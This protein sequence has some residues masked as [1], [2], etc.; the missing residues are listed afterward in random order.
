MRFGRHDEHHDPDSQIVGDRSKSWILQSLAPRY[1][2]CGDLYR[3]GDTGLDKQTVV[4]RLQA[5]PDPYHSPVGRFHVLPD[6]GLD[7]Y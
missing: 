2:D 7:T 4:N 6:C 5:L 1:L 3:L